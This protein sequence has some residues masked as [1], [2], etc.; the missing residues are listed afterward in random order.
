MQREYA[1]LRIS[2]IFKVPPYLDLPTVPQ[3]SRV[4]FSK[5]GGAT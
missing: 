2:V 1:L 3:A 5:K 4:K